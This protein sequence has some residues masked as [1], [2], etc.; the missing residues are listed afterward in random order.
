LWDGEE[1]RFSFGLRPDE[2]AMDAVDGV[3]CGRYRIT[4]TPTLRLGDSRLPLV[5]E[6]EIP[7]SGVEVEFDL[8]D[9]G[10][11]ELDVVD[12]RGTS[13]SADLSGWI[14]LNLESRARA[15]R[16]AI[17]VCRHDAPIVDLVPPGTYSASVSL[18]RSFGGRTS[19]DP[20]PIVP[21]LVVEPGRITRRTVV[22]HP[23]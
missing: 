3:P 7:K 8:S 20:I 10:G 18:M 5:Q 16:R 2:T 1:P 14:H 22:V 6:I 11:V 17:G 21:E 15:S 13:V 9:L 23:R 4:C 19:A 12:E